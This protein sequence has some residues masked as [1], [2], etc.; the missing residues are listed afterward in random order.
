MLLNE[1]GDFFDGQVTS[2]FHV[3]MLLGT[4]QHLGRTDLDQL[5]AL[6]HLTNECLT[7][8]DHV[9]TPPMI[10]RKDALVPLPK[11][12]VR[13]TEREAL[14]ANRDR[15]EHTGVGQLLEHHLTLVLELGLVRIRLR[16]KQTNEELNESRLSRTKIYIN[17]DNRK[18]SSSPLLFQFCA[19]LRSSAD[20]DTSDVVRF[21]CIQ[22]RH[23]FIQLAREF[24][25]E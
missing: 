18:M 25:T 23:E 15:F 21:G 16:D 1:D 5:Q 13:Q 20:L 8:V 2:Q 12:G 19:S 22:C 7:I 10:V 3:A 9:L 14:L 11:L 6:L 24:R 4:I 17:G